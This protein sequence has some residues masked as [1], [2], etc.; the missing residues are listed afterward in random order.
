[1]TKPIRTAD[2]LP[3]DHWIARQ[4][5]AGTSLR[6]YA[7]DEAISVLTS[8]VQDALDRAGVSRAEAARLLGTTR[9][10]VSQ[11]LNGSSNMTLRT[12]GGLLWCAGKQAAALRL[13]D[14]GAAPVL[15]QWPTVSSGTFVVHTAALPRPVTAQVPLN[16]AYPKPSNISVYA[17]RVSQGT[18][19]YMVN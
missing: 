7:E 19:R 10:N 2:D 1:M 17:P 8:A 3:R 12:L 16:D 15:E 5:P 14:I 6:S 11:A 4:L 9:S 18:F 13:D